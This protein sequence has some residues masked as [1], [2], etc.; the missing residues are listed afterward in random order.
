MS[1]Q[2]RAAQPAT[3]QTAAERQIAR[4]RDLERERAELQSRITK[5]RDYLRLMDSNEELTKEQGE[6]LDAFYPMKEKGERRSKEEIERTRKAK[7]AARKPA[8]AATTTANG[9]G[10]TDNAGGE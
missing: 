3:E 7:E 10:A 9:D 1:P 4:A 6:W 2:P 5:N 8:E